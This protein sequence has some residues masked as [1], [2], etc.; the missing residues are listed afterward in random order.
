M[1]QILCLSFKSSVHTIYREE[2]TLYCWYPESF[3]WNS[4]YFERIGKYMACFKWEFQ[5][6]LSI[7]LH[8]CST[9][10]FGQQGGCSFEG[11]WL[12]V[13]PE[14]HV[15]VLTRSMLRSMK[16]W[17]ILFSYTKPAVTFQ[18]ISSSNFL[19]KYTY[20]RK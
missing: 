4:I 20:T 7:G 17:Y 15:F 16:I 8:L 9:K 18:S 1:Q 2:W 5:F 11:C 19:I 12:N 13:F 6:R 14:D 10:T 3:G